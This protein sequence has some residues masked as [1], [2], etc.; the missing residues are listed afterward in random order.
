MYSLIEVPLFVNKD[1][2]TFSKEEA[3]EYFRW[4]KEIKAT[5]LQILEDAVCR[6][7]RHWELNYTRESLFSLY[8][9][10]INKISYRLVTNEEEEEFKS[11]I[12]KTPLLIEAIETPEKTFTDETVSICF[13]IGCYFGDTIIFNNTEARWIQKTNSKKFID[14]AQPLIEINVNN[15]PFNPRRVI[16]NIARL[17]LDNSNKLF[18]FLELFDELVPDVG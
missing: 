15:V 11:Q 17:K 9:W 10:F 4:F 3:K 16:E 7:Y 2:Y 5:R 13:D 18:S 14:Y 6:D 12:S 1:I 8:E